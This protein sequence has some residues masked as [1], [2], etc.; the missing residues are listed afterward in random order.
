MGTLNF[1]TAKRFFFRQMDDGAGNVEILYA[2][3]GK[4]YIF[5]IFTRND[6]QFVITYFVCKAHNVRFLFDDAF[7]TPF[8]A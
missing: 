3:S 8:R 6:C 4:E 2:G 7:R 1:P 5:I